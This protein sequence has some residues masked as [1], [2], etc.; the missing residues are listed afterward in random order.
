MSNRR[1]ANRIESQK[2]KKTRRTIPIICRYDFC[3]SLF[4][5]T[6]P[7]VAF[8]FSFFL[9]LF[10]Y[11]CCCWYYYDSNSDYIFIF[12]YS[13]CFVFF[14]NYLF[15]FFLFFFRVCIGRFHLQALHNKLYT[16]FRQKQSEKRI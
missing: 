10:C 4:F 8:F 1:C 3:H 12:L 6:F 9:Y 7:A 5:L 15:F 16:D 13:I 11:C 2:E 14:C